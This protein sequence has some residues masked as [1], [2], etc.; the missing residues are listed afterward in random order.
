MKKL[1]TYHR[2]RL[3]IGGTGSG[4]GK[5][6]LTL[7]LLAAF[8]RRGLTVQGFKVGPDYID[9]TYHTAVTGRPSRNLDTWMTTP[10]IMREVFLR[11]SRGADLSIIEGVMGYYDGKDPRSNQGSTAQVSMLLQAPTIL[12]VNIA[13]MARSAAAIVKGFCTLT[14]GV[15]IAGVV[16][17]QAGSAGHINLVRT[18]IEQDCGVPLLGGFTRR[19][20]IEIPERHL[21]LIPAVER[22]ELAPLFA[23]LADLVEE[24][25]DLDEILEI[26]RSAPA[27]QAPPT[28]HLFGHDRPP[29]RAKI[30]VARD[31]AFN[32]YYAENLELLEQVGA[33][34]HYFSPLAGESIPVDADALY[35]GG[36]FPE[37]FAREL[38]D[39]AQVRAD[40][41]NRI[42]AGLPTL[43]ECGGYMYLCN[44]ITD[45]AGASYEMVGLIPSDVQMQDRLAAL[46]YRE[47]A[48][49]TPHFLLPLGEQVRGHEFHYSTATEAPHKAYVTQGMRGQKEEGYTCE[50]LVA[51]YTHLYFPSNPEVPKRFVA[52]AVAYG[53][54]RRE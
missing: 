19:T 24:H 53:R 3:A 12:L 8:K 45:R 11:G 47:A 37:E 34:L 31:A 44:T 36:G 17:N 14:E 16:A 27:L 42:T 21:G 43:A 28:P 48:A 7:G 23:K 40:F 32:F 26:A 1:E 18:A 49:A 50:N 2:P 33:E 9:P 46:G 51:G 29:S 54:Q 52:A 38:H 15:P 30:A 35:L 39:H 4:V 41:R 20:D 5:T 10:E 22:G 13:S 25:I 6:T